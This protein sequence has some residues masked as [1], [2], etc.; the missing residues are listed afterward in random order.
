MK[1]LL[2]ILVAV[3]FLLPVTVSATPLQVDVILSLL[4]AGVS[5]VSIQRY[6][7]RNGFTLNLSAD[8]LKALKK[9]GASNALVEFL[10]DREEGAP[11][12]AAGEQAGPS[13][14][15]EEGS[16]YAVESP[17]PDYG[18]TSYAPSY[19][20]GLYY[21]YPYYYS[22]YYYPY[23]YSYPYYYRPYPYYYPYYGYHSHYYG[24]GHGG[25]GTGVVSYWQH[26][27]YYPGRGPGH[28][29]APAPAPAPSGSSHGGHGGG[30]HGGG[31][32]GGGH[33]RH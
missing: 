9:A 19:S 28:S 24:G 22:S 7:E 20:F 18:V 21:G 2:L 8:D 17:S 6:V 27:H 5:D 29:G 30:G 31:H 10:Q 11:S 25:G 26:N 33:G 12:Q 14:T 13:T 3:I 15:T 1:K 16:G 23:Y 4:D 32:G